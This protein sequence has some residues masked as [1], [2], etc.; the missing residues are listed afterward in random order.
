[1]LRTKLTPGLPPVLGDGLMLRRIL[2]NL[3]GNAVDSLAGRPEGIVT[4]TTEPAAAASPGKDQRG[5]HRSRHDSAG[6]G[7]SIR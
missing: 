5:G 2:E 4:V 1:M 6:A 7:S 3:V